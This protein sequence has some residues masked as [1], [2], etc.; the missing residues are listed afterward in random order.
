MATDMASFIDELA[1]PNE[2]ERR[3]MLLEDATEVFARAFSYC[4]TYGF[5]LCV[6][7][8]EDPGA[9]FRT[10]DI[11]SEL[12]LMATRVARGVMCKS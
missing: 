8:A 3:S 12:R 10:D 1:L 5:G 2:P 9:L 7:Q 11:Q 4:A 6:L